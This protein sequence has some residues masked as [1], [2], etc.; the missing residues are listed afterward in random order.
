MIP[1][2]PT[3]TTMPVRSGTDLQANGQTAPGPAATSGTNGDT[4]SA[5]KAETVQA[6]D[7]AQQGADTQGLPQNQS[8]EEARFVEPSRLSAESLTRQADAPDAKTPAGPPPTFDWSVL[9]KARALAASGTQETPEPRPEPE[10]APEV[11]SAEAPAPQTSG[12]QADAPRAE[13]QT[14]EPQKD[15]PADSDPVPTPTAS[16]PAV[17]SPTP[18]G[19]EPE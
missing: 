13:M 4:K 6:V 1:S 9:E 7:P 16:K 10:P 18:P 15:A 11:E 3:A 12:P 2:G 8:N 14:P 5:T 17:D 19:V